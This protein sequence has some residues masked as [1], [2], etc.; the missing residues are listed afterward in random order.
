MT[1]TPTP[2]DKDD[3]K[4][5]VKAAY[6]EDGTANLDLDPKKDAELFKQLS[7]EDQIRAHYNAA[8]GSIQD[9]ARM[10]RLTVEEVLTILGMDD[11]SEITTVGDL[12]D[13]KEA[14]PEVIV[15]PRGK[16]AQAN[17]STN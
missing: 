12:I 1:S 5:P 9:Y 8:R 13:Q 4:A 16:V 7:M 14:G 6:N 2:D 11:M 10:W 3:K 15:N 17:Y